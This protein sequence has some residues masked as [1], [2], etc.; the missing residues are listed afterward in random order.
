MMMMMI[1]ELNYTYLTQKDTIER[2]S[3]KTRAI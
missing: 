2:I 1:Y 3:E